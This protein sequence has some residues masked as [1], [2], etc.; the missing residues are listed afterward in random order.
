MRSAPALRGAVLTSVTKFLGSIPDEAVQVRLGGKMR[1]LHAQAPACCSPD[2]FKPS[3]CSGS[4]THF[5]W[6]SA[7]VTNTLPHLRSPR[8]PRASARSPCTPCR[9]RGS[10]CGGRR[11]AAGAGGRAPAAAHAAGVPRRA[12]LR[13]PTA[14]PWAR[15]LWRRR[16]SSSTCRG[17]RARCLFCCARSTPRCGA[18]HTT[19]SRGCGCCT[20]SCSSGATRRQR[21]RP[22]AGGSGLLWTPAATGWAAA[23]AGVGAG[24]RGGRARGTRRRL[25]GTRL[26]LSGRWVSLAPR[27]AGPTLNCQHVGRGL[28][29]VVL[30]RVCAARQ[31]Q[32]HALAVRKPSSPLE[33]FWV[34]SNT[35]TI[36]TRPRLR[37]WP[38]G[39]A[40]AARGDHLPDGRPGGGGCGLCGCMQP[41]LWPLPNCLCGELGA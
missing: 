25:L 12:A 8:R 1:W 18:T 29:W 14:P 11:A 40:R 10:T 38:G 5:D 17:L 3:A 9:S 27:A 41:L 24:W 34:D 31:G 13:A 15:A 39:A 36:Q 23:G 22:A 6:L 30:G 33:H 2:G 37:R 19:A 35:S 4:T 28:G 26:S 7:R 20:S 16:R 32:R 21:R